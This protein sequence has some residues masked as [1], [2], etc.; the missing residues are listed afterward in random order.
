MN[1]WFSYKNIGIYRL[2]NPTLTNESELY[3]NIQS[4]GIE[5]LG[6]AWNDED[7]SG[8]LILSSIITDLGIVESNDFLYNTSF[9]M[10]VYN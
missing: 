2:H 1:I 10:R 5:S 4:K 7:G 6:C 9:E 8:A 3:F